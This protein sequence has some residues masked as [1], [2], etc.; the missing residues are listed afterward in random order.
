[1]VVFA[2]A[3]APRATTWSGTFDRG[4]VLLEEVDPYYHLRRIELALANDLALPSVDTY[5]NHPTGATVDWPPGFD[6]GFALAWHLYSKVVPEPASP[7]AF[8]AVGVAVL[9]AAAAAGLALLAVRWG[10]LAGL[11]AGL[12]LAW[13]P[14]A[15]AYSRVGRL[16]H[17]A[18]EPLCLVALCVAY[19]WFRRR[20]TYPRAATLGILLALTTVV[21]IGSAFYAAALALAVALEAG[22]G[23]E[24]L[25]R[26]GAITWGAAAVTSSA[27]ALLSPWGRALDVVYYGLSWFQPIVFSG[28]ALAFVVVDR[29]EAR[30]AGRR[31]AWALGGGSVALVGAVLLVSSATGARGFSFLLTDDPVAAT[32]VESRSITEAGVAYTLA[33]LGPVGLALPALWIASAVLAVRRRG[34]DPLLAAALAMGLLGTLLALLQLR[35]APHATVTA[36]LLVAWLLQWMRRPVVSR[37]AVIALAAALGWAV[38]PS[39]LP[40]SMVHPYL[41]G[42]FDALVW[43]RRAPP[44][45][46]HYHR[47]TEH[48]EYAVAAE[49]VWGHW[50]TQIGRKPNIANPLGQ[51]PANL[52]GTEEIARLFLEES[53]AEALVRLDRLGVRY[54]LLS[55]IPVTVADLAAQ[56]G[57][58]PARYVARDAG[59][60]DVFRDA[61]YDTFHSRLYLG[62]GAGAEGTEP[63]SRI[64]LVFESRARIAF[65]GSRPAVRIFEVVPGATLVGR[66]AASA[67]E[68]RVALEGADLVYTARAEPGEGGGFA[69]NVPYATESA[70]AS[71]PARITVRC[72]AAEAPV[73]VPERAVV[74]GLEVPVPGPAV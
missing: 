47:P 17:H 28:V 48:P 41:L 37:L 12:T 67:V 36:A 7:A 55:A 64:R 6:V 5:N 16:D 33:W 58:D 42:G 69:L 22:T 72:G 49:W 52:R 45:T 30:G 62:G 27:L 13:S 60:G 9:G 32:L 1:V 63:L 29:L 19:V 18:I 53:E 74:E 38:R 25:A 43:L 23:G 10:L 14:A 73:A 57:R 56:A 20:S 11:A 59:G 24:A 8:G 65:R 34:V 21:W 61:F 40:D 46:S 68:A 4:V 51:A 44:P 39:T 15:V 50:I 54:L 3:L 70:R 31:W 2:A 71:I 66:C 35:F 26:R